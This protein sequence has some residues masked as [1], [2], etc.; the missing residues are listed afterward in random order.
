MAI[1]NGP[2]DERPPFLFFPACHKVWIN[3]KPF[4]R[5]W[6]YTQVPDQVWPPKTFN[7][8]THS[9]ILPNEVDKTRK[10]KKS[11]RHNQSRIIA[12]TYY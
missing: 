12:Q 6:I 4:F 8:T 5:A 11:A 9:L 1:D 3:D 7:L 2:A 10:E